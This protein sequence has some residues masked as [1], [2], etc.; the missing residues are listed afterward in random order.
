MQLP[1]SYVFTG[2]FSPPLRNPVVGLNAFDLVSI[3]IYVSPLLLLLCE[4]AEHQLEISVDN[5]IDDFERT[6]SGIGHDWIIGAN[7][8]AYEKSNA[9]H[10]HGRFLSVEEPCH[11]RSMGI[12]LA[13]ARTLHQ[14]VLSEYTIDFSSELHIELH[15]GA[16]LS[17]IV[18]MGSAATAFNVQSYEQAGAVGQVVHSGC[19]RKWFRL[20]DNAAGSAFHET[21]MSTDY[22]LVISFKEKP[23]R[24]GYLSHYDIIIAKDIELTIEGKRS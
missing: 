2:G 17:T 18:A 24:R 12:S 19:S 10:A 5:G 16:K 9:R 11:G 14:F 13:Y 1:Q 15:G 20:T 23:A 8:L 22:S 21:Q 3:G 6:L 7:L 4:L